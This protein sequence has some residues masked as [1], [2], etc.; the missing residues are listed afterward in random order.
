MTAVAVRP[1]RFSESKFRQESRMSR[2]EYRKVSV[3]VTQ[4]RNQMEVMLPEPSPY[5]IL[6]RRIA[7][8]R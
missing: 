7:G 6:K 2:K 1:P 5:H 4:L 8:Q 3:Q